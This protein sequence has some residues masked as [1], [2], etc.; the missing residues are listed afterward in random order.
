MILIEIGG[1]WDFDVTDVWP[2]GDAPEEIDAAA[3]ATVMQKYGKRRVL[4]EWGFMD[5]LSIDIEVPNPH[6]K[7]RESL[8][9]E[10]AP[11]PATRAYVS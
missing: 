7:Q 5:E 2:D 1:E 9:P 10:L 6:W 3:V 8:F 11:T 4:D